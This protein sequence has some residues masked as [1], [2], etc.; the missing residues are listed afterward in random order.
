MTRRRREG[1][2]YRSKRTEENRAA[3][4]ATTRRDNI[5]RYGRGEYVVFASDNR[6]QNVVP[7]GPRRNR[8]RPW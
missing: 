1:K 5:P 8:P 7:V 3:A 6:T 4:A 2:H